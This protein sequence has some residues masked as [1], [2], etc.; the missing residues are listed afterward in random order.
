MDFYLQPN[1]GFGVK[2]SVGAG[3]IT[4]VPFGTWRRV[5]PFENALLITA[6]GKAA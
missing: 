3:K 2:M 6:G 4:K 1:V 5:A